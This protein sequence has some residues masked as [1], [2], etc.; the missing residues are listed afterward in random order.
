MR[1]V[2]LNSWPDCD[3]AR[4]MEREAI[5]GAFA[6]SSM[7]SPVTFALGAAAAGS[8][9][10]WQPKTSVSGRSEAKNLGMLFIVRW[11]FQRALSRAQRRDGLRRV[12]ARLGFGRADFVVVALGVEQIQ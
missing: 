11:K 8:S 3:S 1:P 6:G 4:P 10:L 5:C 9:R 12:R 2:K 7:I